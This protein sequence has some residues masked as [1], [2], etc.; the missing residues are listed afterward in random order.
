MMLRGLGRYADS[1]R[2]SARAAMGGRG[3]FGWVCGLA[4]LSSGCAT[5]VVVSP[6]W[7]SVPGPYELGDAYPDFAARIGVSGAA[8]LECTGLPDGALANC[9]ATEASPSGLGFDQAALRL[10]PRFRLSPRQRNGEPVKGRIRFSIRFSLPPQEAPE[11]WTGP[12]PSEEALAAARRLAVRT[13]LTPS[14]VDPANLDIDPARHEA[15]LQM[16]REVEPEGRDDMVDAFALALARTYPI[17]ILE[18]SAVGQRR[19]SPPSDPAL[20]RRALDRF[21]AISQARDD[22]LRERYCGKFDCVIKLTHVSREPSANLPA[23]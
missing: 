4:L 18:L 8:T 11:P 15:V 22:R 20:F 13:P 14:L 1:Q 16:I 6:A 2:G 9:R 5:S 3:V 10:T 21:T 7:D 23:S 19:L 12:E 17:A